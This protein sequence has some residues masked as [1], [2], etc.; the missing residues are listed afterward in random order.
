VAKSQDENAKGKKADKPS[1]A[2]YAFWNSYNLTFLGGAAAATLTTGY[3]PLSVA[4]AAAEAVWMLFAPDSRLL[5][6]MWFDKVWA[7]DKA[8]LRARLRQETLAR[9]NDKDRDRASALTPVI[10]RIERLAAENPSFAGEL[11]RNELVHLNEL[12]DDFVDVLDA[13]R[14][15]DEHLHTIDAKRLEE[16]ERRFEKQ[17]EKS[18]VGEDARAMAQKNLEVVLLRLER[19]RELRSHLQTARG[20]LDLIENTLRLLAD[21]I[22]TMRSPREMGGRLEELRSGVE[23]V[24]ETARE[25]EQPWMQLQS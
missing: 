13:C 3:W 22:M 1:Y 19:F 15:Y 18:N 21:D 14:R 5:Q 2:K 11:L 6:H 12:A 16:D 20:Q 17:I 25:T 7:E 4:A 9:M 10:Q 8:K 23:A 24:R